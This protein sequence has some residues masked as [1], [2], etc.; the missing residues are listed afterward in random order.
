MT[1][2]QTIALR[3]NLLQQLN[4]AGAAGANEGFLHQGADFAVAGVTVREV[5][6]ALDHLQNFGFATKS[7]NPLLGSLSPWKITTGGAE[8]LAAA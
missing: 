7:N 4:E 5:R 3:R 1:E 2:A 6:D 8:A